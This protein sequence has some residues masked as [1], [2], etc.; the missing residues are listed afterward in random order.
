MGFSDGNHPLQAFGEDTIV[1]QNYF[2][3]VRLGRDL[4]YSIIV[5]SYLA[6]EITIADDPNPRISL[7]V[8]GG[9]LRRTAG[10]LIVNHK[11][12]ESGIRLRKHALDAL[13]KVL[14]GVV[15]RRHHADQR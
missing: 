15:E 9:D 12:L 2:Q 11:V 14:S 8:L 7:S 4:A 5:V 10:T 6:H 3:V 13:A 1:G